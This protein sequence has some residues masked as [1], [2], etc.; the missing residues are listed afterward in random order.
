MGCDHQWDVAISHA[1]VFMRSESHAQDLGF[2]VA[3]SDMFNLILCSFI[4]LG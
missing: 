4:D 1:R 3:I 2:E